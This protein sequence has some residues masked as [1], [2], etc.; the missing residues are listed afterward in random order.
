MV[1]YTIEKGE[2][3]D[4]AVVKLFLNKKK[5]EQYVKYHPYTKIVERRTD[6]DRWSLGPDRMWVVGLS[7][8]ILKDDEHHYTMKETFDYEGH[9]S[10]NRVVIERQAD[11]MPDV[12]MISDYYDRDLKKKRRALELWISRSYPED[13]F[14]NEEDD[15]KK[16]KK[17]AEDIANEVET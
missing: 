15:Y 6:D 2:Y 10:I 8:A 3:S 14:L 12:T 5:A 16:V 1:I 9:R 7:F 13:R 4:Y 11:V 17:I